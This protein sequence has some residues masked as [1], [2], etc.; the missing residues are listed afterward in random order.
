MLGL[1]FILHFLHIEYIYLLDLWKIR[2]IIHTYIYV[3]N[4]L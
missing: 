4:S 2:N 3:Y 1:N